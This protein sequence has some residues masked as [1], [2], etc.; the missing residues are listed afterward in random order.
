LALACR[1]SALIPNQARQSNFMSND[2]LQ[3][4]AEAAPTT[5]AMP[6]PDL[7]HESRPKS[8]CQ[9]SVKR[10]A[11]ERSTAP[12]LV[13]VLPD[14]LLLKVPCLRKHLLPFIL[15]RT[16]V[17]PLTPASLLVHHSSDPFLC[18]QVFSELAKLGT[19]ARLA[20]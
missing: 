4:V 16:A 20:S 18:L 15:V 14:E 2:L 8:A 1:N 12:S 9:R 5:S 10:Q 17:H 3:E 19:S 13:A 6:H 7:A 11:T